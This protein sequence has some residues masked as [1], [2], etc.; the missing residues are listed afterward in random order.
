MMNMLCLFDVLDDKFIEYVLI[1]GWKLCDC[2]VCCVYVSMLVRCRLVVFMVLKLVIIVVLFINGYL[3]I[4]FDVNVWK[5]GLWVS[6]CCVKC[7]ICC[8]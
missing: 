3:C 8:C 4:G 5:Y 2:L 7:L 6:M 1:V